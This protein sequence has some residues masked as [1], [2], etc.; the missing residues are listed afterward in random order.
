MNFFR[1]TPSKPVLARSDGLWFTIVLFFLLAFR[2]PAQTVLQVVTKSTEKEF[3]CLDSDALVL[4]AEKADVLVRGWDRAVIRVRISLIAKHADRQ[5]AE[6][7]VQ[8]LQYRIDRRG[9]TTEL[10]NFF[11]IPQSVP[12][13]ESTLKARYEVFLPERCRIQIQNSFGVT[14][15]RNLSGHVQA[16]SEFGE[17]KLYD[18]GGTVVIQS[19][20]A[21]VTGQRLDAVLTCRAEKADVRLTDLGGTTDL[22]GTY[23]NLHLEP[24]ERLRRLSVDAS[25]SAI[26]LV[27]PRWDSFRYDIEAPHGRLIVP[28]TGPTTVPGHA[29]RSSRLRSGRTSTLPEIRLRTSFKSITLQ[30]P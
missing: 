21:N 23:G 4:R 10:S 12:E 1:T 8:Y 28:E 9:T 26:T 17:I 24:T 25:R 5:R 20:Y 11:R 19:T 18:L 6:R 14:E 27:V 2:L 29:F 15:L 30:T 7:E 13:V 16:T 22:R 3:R